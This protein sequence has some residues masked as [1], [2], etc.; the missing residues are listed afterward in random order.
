MNPL[1]IST[2]INI[3]I[4]LE[5]LNEFDLAEQSFLQSLTLYKEFYGENNRKIF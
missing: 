5:E 2:I 4:A 3:G 1:T